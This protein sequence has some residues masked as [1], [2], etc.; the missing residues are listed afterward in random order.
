M[1]TVGVRNIAGLRQAQSLSL[2]VIVA[3]TLCLNVL[4]G[5]RENDQV[6]GST[7]VGVLL[8]RG[9]HP[10]CTASV[11][12]SPRGNLIITAA[13][14]LGRRLAPTLMFAPYYHDKKAPLGEWQVTGQVFPPGWFPYGNI[15][16]DFALLTVQG[17]VQAHA[18]AESLGFSLPPPVL[19]RV[20]GYSLVGRLTICDRRPGLIAAAGQRQ[21]SFDCPGYT[22]ASSGGPFLTGI[23]GQS[24]LGTIVGIIGGYQKGGS[25]S[26]VS[27]SSPFG[28][29]L[30][31][32]YDA[33]TRVSQD[34]AAEPCLGFSAWS[35]G[36]SIGGHVL[37]D[38]PQSLGQL[39]R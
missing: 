9:Q 14:C 16:Q 23:N 39:M 12:N 2:A 19:V 28:L 29:I 3:F 22:N 30:H 34:T 10:F 26:S 6:S 1:W 27:Y 8:L 37:C 11:V 5:T 21:L 33:M 13:H 18:G 4:A 15:N 32:M 36:G 20:E 25:T 35:L 38:D 7:A 24:G 31:R 17:D